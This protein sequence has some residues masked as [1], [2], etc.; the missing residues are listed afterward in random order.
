[1]RWNFWTKLNFFF[2]FKKEENIGIPWGRKKL[3]CFGRHCLY[4]S[5]L[6][7]CIFILF[8]TVM[9]ED[10]QGFTLHIFSVLELHLSCQKDFISAP[11]GQ[12]ELMISWWD[13]LIST[14]IWGSH[15]SRNNH[16]PTVSSFGFL[17]VLLKWHVCPQGI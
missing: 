3:K 13:D 4:F 2:F 9:T 8:L 5:L 1:M 10:N 14:V 6:M 15:R 12:I 7:L 11:T 17:A 16:K